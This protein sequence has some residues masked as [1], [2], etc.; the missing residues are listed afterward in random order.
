MIGGAWDKMGGWDIMGGGVWYGTGGGGDF[1]AENFRHPQT[2]GALRTDA[3]TTVLGIHSGYTKKLFGIH[4]G[5]TKSLFGIHG[6]HKKSF[7]D[8]HEHKDGS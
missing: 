8:I 6:I 4:S 7:W 2:F 3:G 5:H 1:R